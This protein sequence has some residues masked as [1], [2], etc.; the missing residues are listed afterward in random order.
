MCSR[1]T[2]IAIFLSS[3]DPYSVKLKL[4]LFSCCPMLS[5]SF[6]SKY[7]SPRVKILVLSGVSR[8]AH[9]GNKTAS[10]CGKKTHSFLLLTQ[11][12][13]LRSSACYPLAILV[14]T[15]FFFLEFALKRFSHSTSSPWPSPFPPAMETR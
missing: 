11:G 10:E 5:F 7:C 6:Q 9:E 2:L 8:K 15:V 12:V 3:Q 13:L 14:N 4:L 1:K